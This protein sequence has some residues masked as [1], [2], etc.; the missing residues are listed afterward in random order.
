MN[1][2]ARSRLRA[3]PDCVSFVRAIGWGETRSFA[4]DGTSAS[5]F[6]EPAEFSCGSQAAK[7]DGLRPASGVVPPH[8]E[9]SALLDE[10][11]AARDSAYSPYSGFAVGAALEDETGRVFRGC[12]VENLSFGLTICA[13]R[14]ALCAAVV[15]G[16]KTFRRIAIVSDSADPVSPCGA[17]RQVLAEFSPRMA[18]ISANRTGTLF[19]SSI[20]QLLPR[21]KTGILG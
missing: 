9:L 20:D 1:I 7:P 10:A 11:W 16:S 13:E 14:T 17:C 21:A 3:T 12:N 4:V 19:E 6:D 18:V 8:M 5:A 15:A 2:S